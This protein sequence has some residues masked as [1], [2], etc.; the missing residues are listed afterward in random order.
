MAQSLSNVIIHVIFSTK[1][2]VNYIDNEI[3]DRIH[4]Y[5]ATIIRDMDGNAFRVGGTGDHIHIAA[6]LPRTVTQS[7]F[8]RKVKSESSKWIKE[9]GI[10]EFSWQRG[11]GIFSI[12][13]SA[14]DVL[15]KYIEGQEAHHKKTTFKE[16]FI[17]FLKK[18]NV[19]FDEKYIWE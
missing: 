3:K 8:I 15:I 2:R 11:F 9:Q 18:Y 17:R 7:D 5:I 12:S 1:D 6:S 4:A 10:N 13:Y 16:E 19:P 14:M